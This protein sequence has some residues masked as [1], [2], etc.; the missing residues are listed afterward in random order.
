VGSADNQRI[1]YIPG[2]DDSDSD[3]AMAPKCSKRIAAVDAQK[4]FSDGYIAGADDSD[5]DPATH[6]RASKRSQGVG[7]YL[8]GIDDSDSEECVGGKFVKRRKARQRRGPP[9][10]D[11]EQAREYQPS[12]VDEERCKALMYNDGYGRLQCSRKP[13]PGKDLCGNHARYGAPHG[14]VRG[15]MPLKKYT[16]FK[17]AATK[18]RS[19]KTKKWYARHLMWQIASKHYHAEV[20][21]QGGGSELENLHE[22]ENGQYKFTD[23]MY[24]KCLDKVHDHIKKH[25]NLQRKY[26]RGAGAEQRNDRLDGGRY[27]SEK[28]RYNGKGGGQVF[29]WYSRNVFNSYLKRMGT[30]ERSCSERQC[31]VALEATTDELRKYPIVTCFLS[32]YAGPQCYPHLDPGSSQYRVHANDRPVEDDG[33]EA[34][35]KNKKQTDGVAEKKMLSRS[36]FDERNWIQCSRC[37]ALRCVVQGSM[38]TVEGDGFFGVRHTDLDWEAWLQNVQSRYAVLAKSHTPDQALICEPCEPGIQG[39]IA[40][41]TEKRLRVCSKSPEKMVGSRALAAA[42]PAMA[43]GNLVEPCESPRRLRRKTFVGAMQVD[44]GE[45]A[46]ALPE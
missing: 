25:P 4:T 27:G 26:E 15:P 12:D 22:T 31:M 7:G 36:A 19:E 28:E 29:K 8:A 35:E 40:T 33:E 42:A 16:E 1:D 18:P 43:A 24:K 2:V 11:D 38:S 3:A 14:R 6:R 39:D 21:K 44:G 34:D 37:D 20:V 32:P 10:V 46:A 9:M 45:E 30:T 5:S 41:K 17:H 13:L 23:E